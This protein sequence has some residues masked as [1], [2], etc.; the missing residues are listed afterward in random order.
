MTNPSSAV[1]EFVDALQDAREAAGS[2]TYQTLIH[3]AEGQQP[4]VTLTASSLGDWFEGRR[5]PADLDQLR[6]LVDFL[7]ER[8]R[9]TPTYQMRDWR[10]WQALYERAREDTARGGPAGSPADGETASKDQVDVL[11]LVTLSEEF[12]A[13]R[14]A[15]L[16]AGSG[17]PGVNEWEQRVTEESVPFLRGEYQTKDGQKFSVALARPTRLGGNGLSTFATLMDRFRPLCVA[18]CGV[19]AGNPAKT[20]LGDVVVAETLFDS[21]RVRLE[22]SGSRNDYQLPPLEE[23]WA[24]AA[25][26][27]DPTDLPSYGPA[28]G[29]EPVLWLLERLYAGE[30]P[31]SDPARTRYFP[32]GNWAARLDQFEK[33]G[34]IARQADRTLA[35][36]DAGDDLL[37]RRMYDNV[38]LPRRLPFRVLVAPM[39]SGDTLVSRPITRSEMLP[40]GF[41]AI[42][43]DMDAL[44]TVR[45]AIDREV[46][47]WLVVKGVMDH[48]GSQK[49]DRYRK[50][51]ARASAEV[52]FA[53]LSRV[54][55]RL[56]RP[57]AASTSSS[58]AQGPGALFDQVESAGLADSRA[59]TDQLDRE[60]VVDVLYTLVTSDAIERPSAGA[61]ISH[62]TGALNGPA[63]IAIQGPWGAGKTSLMHL[64]YKRLPAAPSRDTTK[65]LTVA[66]AA[67][68]LA[69]LPTEDRGTDLAPRIW[70]PVWF[71]PW[72]HQSGEQLWA[73]LAQ[74]IIHRLD[75]FLRPS[76]R[77]AEA[78]WLRRNAERL[79][80]RA[81]RRSLLLRTVSPAF[82]FAVW[83]TL[84][85][86]L[87]RLADPTNEFTIGNHV[88]LNA[89]T[90][91]LILPLNLVTW[92][93]FQTAWR[94]RRAPAAVFLPADLLRGPVL[95]GAHAESAQ[96]EPQLR[97]PLYHARSGY[98]YL[99]QHDVKR[100]LA[101]AGRSGYRIVVFIDDLDR[102]SPQTTADVL[103]AVNLFLTEEFTHARFVIGLDPAVVASHVKQAFSNTSGGPFVTYGDDPHPGWTFLRKLVQLPVELPHIDDASI[104]KLL[105][106]GLGE[107]K[108]DSSERPS[109]HENPPAAT[110]DGQPEAGGIDGT[111]ESRGPN[112]GA[113]LEQFGSPTVSVTNFLERSPRVRD[114]LTE[115]LR[116]QPERS[117]REIKRLVTIWI[118]YVRLLAERGRM[119]ADV[120]EERA[121]Q[122]LFLAEIAARWPAL[123]RHLSRRVDD[124]TGIAVLIHAAG[125][126]QAWALALRR[127]TLNTAEHQSACK[128]LRALILKFDLTQAAELSQ[129]VS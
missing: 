32:S 12:E 70:V 111:P 76:T 91:A 99:Y 95:S 45:L 40:P 83:A 23:E 26:G 100:L 105:E 97:D 22:S 104:D 124:Q 52:L 46:P 38:E 109:G 103:S 15:G 79:D 34:L 60:K 29:D 127:L 85:P 44:A 57:G 82:K 78:Y 10:W 1:K 65:R 49:Y 56:T 19:C 27:L 18:T 3:H 4:P 118:Y 31:Q 13:A 94:Y 108:V 62:T 71:N 102:C 93:A 81:I 77:D 88:L 117:V 125:N 123:Q 96:S 58:D 36:T 90:F 25:E 63:V 21:A 73:G 33:D 20:A 9:R 84:V 129:W 112:H 113:Q 116:D 17:W 53:L 41:P 28:D 37:W 6:L 42:A 86:L 119:P 39:A 7:Q 101:D 43:A 120:A 98:L 87:A 11:L 50:F 61:Q 68:L 35:L 66:E 64:I 30:D 16:P 59:E 51:A 47:H 67:G 110:S 128:N 107:I 48:A 115:R 69:A 2:P 80:A 55:T 126:E 121:C 92:G 54:A 74:N 106:Y 5:L 89:A 72:A 24:R 8:A 75:D 114:L 14:A 122:L